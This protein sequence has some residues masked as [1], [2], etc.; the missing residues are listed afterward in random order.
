MNQTRLR[1]IVLH[2]SGKSATVKDGD[3]SANLT[4]FHPFGVAECR[5]QDITHARAEG[6]DHG[7]LE[8]PLL[9]SNDQSQKSAGVIKLEVK[10][11]V[12]MNLLERAQLA[13]SRVKVARLGAKIEGPVFRFGTTT[14]SGEVRVRILPWLCVMVG[15]SF[16]ISRGKFVHR[17]PGVSGALYCRFEPCF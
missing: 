9:D 16:Y 5:I 10:D 13:A 11:L 14:A 2:D 17:S 15:C 7:C 1:V 3:S 4:G 8:L 12:P 6:D